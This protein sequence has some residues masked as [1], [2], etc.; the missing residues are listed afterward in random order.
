MALIHPNLSKKRSGRASERKWAISRGQLTERLKMILL[1]VIVLATGT[2][3]SVCASQTENGS[4]TSD[5]PQ[6]PQQ[7][8]AA[9]IPQSEIR[10]I[11]KGS[12]PAN[13][14]LKQIPA[15]VDIPQTPESIER[16]LKL[17][18]EGEKFFQ[19][20]LL[21]KALTKWQEAYGLSLEMKYAEGEGRA[22]TNM[23]RLFLERG[24]FVKAKYMGEN[25]I[26]VLGGVSDRK[27]LGRA[28]LY[29]AQAY[30]G[31]ENPVWAG[32]QLDEA[33]KAFTA[34][35]G[36]NAMDTATLMNLAAAVLIN[37]GKVRE[38]MQFYQA[39][40]TYYSQGGDTAR[41]IDSHLRIVDILL[42]FGLLTAAEEQAE[43][44]VSLARA[45]NSQ[46]TE[47]IAAL[48]AQANCWYS[49]GEYQKAKI[50]Y[51]QA[52]ELART[53]PL[54]KL[55][56]VAR[57]SLDLGYGSTLVG[58]GD[59]DG[60]RQHLE[61]ALTIFKS[62]G[63]S[64]S[65]AQAANALAVLEDAQGHEEK[66]KSLLETALD[67][68]NLIVPKNDNFHVLIL[69]NLASI[70]SRVGQN[71]AARAHLETAST[72]LKKMKDT[73]LLARTYAAA[74]EVSIKLAEDADADRFVHEAISLSAQVNDDSA[75][76]REHT[77][78]A[79]LQLAQGNVN[80]ARESLMSALS[81]F[82]SPQAG[83]FPSPERIP[84]PTARIDMAQQLI[85]MLVQQKMTEQALLATEQI[86]EE[87]FINTWF[88]RGGQVR[89]D[90][91]EMYADLASQRAHLHAAEVSS[92][93]DKIVKD[94]QAWM[95]RF[96]N[97]LAQNRNLARLIAPVPISM[98]EITKMLQTA[99]SFALEYLVSSESTVVF[100][101]SGGNKIAAAV[102]PVGYKKLEGQISS[103]LSNLA[104]RA[105]EKENYQAPLI[106]KNILRAVYGELIPPHVNAVLPTDSEHL[107]TI[108]PDG[109]L[110]N[111]PFAALLDDQGKY[112][113]EKHTITLACS[114][115]SLVNCPS[116]YHEDLSLLVVAA[117]PTAAAEPADGELA[118]NEIADLF[119]PEAFNGLAGKY[120]DIKSIQ[121]QARGKAA[122]QLSDDFN[123]SYGNLWKDNL[124]FPVSRDQG[125]KPASISDL[126]GLSIP[127]DL[128]ICSASHLDPKAVDGNVL[129]V[130]SRGLNYAGVRNV[131][132]TLW[133]EPSSDR[134]R[135]LINIYKNQQ[136]GLS[137]AES[138]RRSQLAAIAN[139]PSPKT[140]AAFQLFGP[141]H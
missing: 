97:L 87:T 33:M 50:L 95:G 130:F 110:F 109:V 102:L 13:V 30:F 11:E 25:A 59:L 80:G 39:A 12:A 116:R 101:V 40:A 61:R 104:T 62:S 32:Q 5:S 2:T 132:T 114:L 65:Q 111:L 98:S 67:L 14:D 37:M 44:A 68:H 15:L 140:W 100:T 36:N 41:A 125:N 105:N 124:P 112:F 48:S 24:Q 66:A 9:V 51:E 122:V 58:Y 78:L 92:S 128:F 83:Y 73:T 88:Q 141:G 45:A 108:V 74:T 121:E 3:S 20:K 94:W 60:A 64:L 117:K 69:Q 46:P 137:L 34:D 81:F 103:L 107:L 35:G 28:H 72:Q 76:W 93:P 79:K 85:A 89:S 42:G 133:L 38:A 84:Y 47:L 27:A 6:N 115:G 127:S 90:D 18:T 57:E 106:E 129:K 123:L 31:L 134:T 139:D 29:L 26:E 10:V 131:L 17:E 96:R 71:R 7:I 22:L 63:G 91:A 118:G 126:F 138:L 43:K 56:A 135:E 99:H 8:G 52:I 54:D 119:R 16:V 136:A 1:S 70:E 53:V 55:N 49:L 82:R 120:A 19:Q 75:L 77:L 113:I 21:D 23:G 4:G 86:K